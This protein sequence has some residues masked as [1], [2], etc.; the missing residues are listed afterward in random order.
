MGVEVDRVGEVVPFIGV[1]AFG[2]AEDVGAHAVVAAVVADG[3]QQSAVGALF[4]FV[5]CAWGGD[6]VHPVLEQGLA[7]EYG[8]KDGAGVQSAV[9]GRGGDVGVV[10]G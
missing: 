4:V 9:G 2:G 3:G 7:G 1:E 8:G 5:V 10:Q 6:L